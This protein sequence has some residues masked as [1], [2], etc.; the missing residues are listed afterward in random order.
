METINR[1]RF[2]VGDRLGLLQDIL[3]WDVLDALLIVV[4]LVNAGMIGLGLVWTLVLNL[5]DICER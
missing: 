1:T 3:V 4:C 5:R 2:P